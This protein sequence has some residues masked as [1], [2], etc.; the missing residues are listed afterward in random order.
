[1]L[2]TTRLSTRAGS[3][4]RCKSAAKKEIM[5]V[6]RAEKNDL[7]QVLEIEE[8]TFSDPWGYYNF[9]SALEDIFL[10]FDEQGISGFLVGVVCH[11]DVKGHI[12]KMAVHPEHRHH[13]IGTQLLEGGLRMLRDGGS[14][15]AC[16]IVETTRKPAIALYRK[17]GFEITAT[18]DLSDDDD[19]PVES[20]YEMKLK[21]SPDLT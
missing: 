5:G 1:M 6:R 7:E 11:R 16:L 8:L 18:I 20:F 9:Q 4:A 3:E 19:A 10:V 12:M 21:L 13:G 2:L 17:F 15:E 14:L